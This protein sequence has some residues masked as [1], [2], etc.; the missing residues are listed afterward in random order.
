MR[1]IWGWPGVEAGLPASGR[2]YRSASTHGVDLGICCG[3]EPMLGC[4]HQAEHRLGSTKRS[5]STRGVDLLQLQ[6]GVAGEFARAEQ[7]AVDHI[8][9]ELLVHTALLSREFGGVQ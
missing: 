7:Q 4:D 5:A 2:H 6:A 9:I 8:G 3:A 1:G